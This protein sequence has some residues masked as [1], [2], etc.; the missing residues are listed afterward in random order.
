[1]QSRIILSII[2]IIL[3]LCGRKKNEGKVHRHG[4]SRFLSKI[5]PSDFSIEDIT[6]PKFHKRKAQVGSAMTA[7]VDSTSANGAKTVAT[8]D[9]PNIK[10]LQFEDRYIH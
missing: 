8:W 9:S 6:Q 7:D 3:Y 5:N 10:S 1:M 2:G 4:V